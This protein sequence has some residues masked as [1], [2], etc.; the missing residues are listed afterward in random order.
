[1][2]YGGYWLNKD[3]NFDNVLTAMLSLFISATTEGWAEIMHDGVDA[4]GIGKQPKPEN[5]FAWS[6]FFVVFIIFGSFFILNLLV[7]VIID[8]FTQEK[9]L[10]RGEAFLSA[11][12]K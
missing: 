7:G 10:E 5:N 2:D 11:E 8:Q 3:S 9:S 12:K 6:L 4:V 1:M